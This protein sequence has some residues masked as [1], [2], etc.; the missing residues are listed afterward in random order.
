MKRLNNIMSVAALF[1]ISGVNAKQV[2]GGKVPSRLTQQQEI[3]GLKRKQE[4]QERE[5]E[6]QR[7]K[8][9]QDERQIE[10]LQEKQEKEQ[11]P[12]AAAPS[13]APQGVSDQEWYDIEDELDSYI[14]TGKLQTAVERIKQIQRM[15]LTRQQRS[16]LKKTEQNIRLMRQIAERPTT[17]EQ[18]KRKQ[19]LRSMFSKWWSGEAGKIE[20]YKYM[21]KTQ[22]GYAGEKCSILLAAAEKYPTSKS[23]K[24]AVDLGLEFFST[25]YNDP[26][27]MRKALRTLKT[28]LPTTA[29][30]LEQER[31][32]VLNDKMRKYF[33]V[34]LAELNG[35]STEEKITYLKNYLAKSKAGMKDFVKEK[36]T[37]ENVEALLRAITSETDRINTMIK[38]LESLKV[39]QE[40]STE[41]V[42]QVAAPTQAPQGKPAGGQ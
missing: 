16:S 13:Q 28:T 27:I 1:A 14:D 38:S 19:P 21:I 42:K 10:Q 41:P 20:N 32:N 8:Q 25:E 30:K 31:I 2:G 37:N 36:I 12:H 23:K 4:I 22:L 29:D 39:A 35:L 34:N 24:E 15:N 17:K 33:D 7:K 3:E 11:A 9:L 5:Q 18:P 26:N 40:K 6:I